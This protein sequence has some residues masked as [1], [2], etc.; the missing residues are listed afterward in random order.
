MR[1]QFYHFSSRRVYA[2]PALGSFGALGAF[3]PLP[4]LGSFGDLGAF[5]PL[6]ALGAL[7]AFDPLP[8][9]GAFDAFV[10]PPPSVQA[11]SIV[12]MVLAH[13]AFSPSE[14]AR[15]KAIASS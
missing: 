4:A 7:G 3:D 5:D 11:P 10:D 6:P 2:L 8:A 12:T 1:L 14:S 13:A 15:A 9:L